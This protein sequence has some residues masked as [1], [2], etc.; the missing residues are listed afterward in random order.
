MLLVLLFLINAFVGINGTECNEPFACSNASI[1]TDP[2]CNGYRSCQQSIGYAITRQLAC[3]G[4]FSC[5]NSIRLWTDDEDIECIGEFSCANSENITTADDVECD[6]VNSCTNSTIVS[7]A[8]DTDELRCEGDS[9]C[10]NSFI[11]GFALINGHG[12]YSLQNSTILSRNVTL[13]DYTSYETI[14]RFDG[15][16]A[17]K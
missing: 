17:G 15:F 5:Y 2:E 10:T 11:H 12:A 4:S 7:V 9:S 3:A 14:V 13:L 16:Y 1:V 8:L 6:G